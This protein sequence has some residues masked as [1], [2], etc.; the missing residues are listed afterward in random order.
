MKSNQH[1]NKH[2]LLSFSFIVICCLTIFISSFFILAPTDNTK[3]LEIL[4]LRQEVDPIFYITSQLTYNHDIAQTW[5]TELTD[6]EPSL[7]TSASAKLSTEPSPTASN[8]GKLLGEGTEL[9]LVLKLTEETPNYEQIATDLAHLKQYFSDISLSILPSGQMSD[10]LYLSCYENLYSVLQDSNLS[11]ISMIAYP[12]ETSQLPL[13]DKEYITSIGTVLRTQDDLADLDKIYTY[14]NGR[15]SLVVR[16]EIR[17]FY[18]NEPQVAT[19]EITTTYYLLAI[20]YA[21][22]ECIF[23]PYIKPPLPDLDAYALNSG[24]ANCVPFY[25]IYDRLLN[26][27]WITTSREAVSTVSPYEAVKDY[28]TISDTAELILAPDAEILRSLKKLSSNEYE[29]YF[30]WNETLLNINLYYP[31]T[32]S[33]DTN[34]EPNGLSRLSVILQNKKTNQNQTYVIDLNI[35]HANTNQRSSRIASLAQPNTEY[36]KPSKNYIPI[37]MY[38]TVEDHVLPE[39]QNSHVETAVFDSQ[40]KALIENGYTPI[41]F[42]DLKNYADGLVS[43]PDKPI[44]ITMDDGYLNNYTH[45]YPIYKKYNI[46]ATLFVSPYYMKTENTER[47]FGWLAAKEMEESGLIDIQPH[48]YDHT[49][50]PYLSVK[51]ATYHASHAR[52]LIEMYLGPRDV[53]VLSYPQFRHNRHTV[54][55]L[56]ELGFDFQIINLAKTKAFELGTVLAPNPSFA[57]PK[58]Q[59]INVP[60]TMSPEELIETLDKV[61]S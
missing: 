55:L 46:Q 17:S 28:D 21:G 57:P 34:L 45:A 36:V 25:T 54:K 48:G 51:D 53:S 16:D 14:F 58:L 12:A 41:N 35:N 5:L 1:F 32:I 22:V 38:H 27:S 29:I 59:R 26:K 52:G 20:Q 40:M 23:S 31:Y 13:Y 56:N 50:L 60:N 7:S 33:I 37:L 3:P 61:T 49:P 18:A 6:S 24:D 39:E 9:N 11:S 44:I 4:S 30:K 19:K 15:K 8:Q 42:H 47:H 10:K 43:L 2:R